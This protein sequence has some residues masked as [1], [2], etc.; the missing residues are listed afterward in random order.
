MI[1]LLMDIVLLSSNVNSIS[2]LIITKL[3]KRKA[4]VSYFFHKL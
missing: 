2:S 4:C 1:S 3:T